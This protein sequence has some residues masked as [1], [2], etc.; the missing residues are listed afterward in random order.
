MRIVQ[1]ERVGMGKS[2][3]ILRLAEELTGKYHVIEPLT[4]IRVHGPNIAEDRIMD[5]LQSLSFR[6]CETLIVHFDISPSVSSMSQLLFTC[7]N[8]STYSFTDGQIC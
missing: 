4:S 1:S 3:Y 6:S 7:N 2:L 8:V 5:Q